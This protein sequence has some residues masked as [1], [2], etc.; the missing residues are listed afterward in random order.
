MLDLTRRAFLQA[1][2]AGG[3]L[4]LRG[5]AGAPVDPIAFWRGEL[6]A[7]A[8]R[9]K[10]EGRLVAAGSDAVPWDEL[11]RL[12]RGRHRDLRRHF[13]FEYYPWYAAHPVRHWQQ[14]DRVPPVDVAANTMPL[15][16]A[17]DSRATAVIEQHA[18]WMAEA[19]VG[20]INLSWWGV[21]SFEDRVT[22]MVMD[23]MHAH[24]I[25]VAFHIEPY[26]PP[27]I[28]RLA[29]DLLYLIRTYGEQRRWDAFFLHER[30]DGT[31]G[32]VFKLFETTLPQQTVDCHGVVR[33]VSDY[34]QDDVW[35]R[36]I[37]RAHRAVDGMFDR[38]TLLSDTWNAVRARDSGLDGIAVY[39]SSVE[40]EA[41]LGFA[42]AATRLGMPFSMNTNAG[43]DEIARRGLPADSCLVPRPFVPRIGEIDWS[44]EDDR[45][46]A[47][48]R[49]VARI[50]ET[51]EWTLLLQTHPW[52][53]NV[54]LGFFLVYITSFNEWHEGSQFEPMRPRGGL[55]A[56][57]R[58]VGYHNPWDG[59]ARLDR[60]T[61]LLRR[62][63]V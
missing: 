29:D 15:L 32:P 18:R 28:D 41:W 45:E 2:L 7:R 63:G 59:F 14:W 21:D 62:L 42:L 38:V 55:T 61:E 50:G 16:G 8:A 43:L 20:V 10:L 23:V 3:G 37:E 57:E 33:A 30:A 56:D 22:P 27:R 54:D 48:A 40:R 9:R 52:L 26:G 6:A 34:V 17:Y 44:R 25:H 13:V 31:A 60:L 51:L 11:G 5:A 47:H 53:G 12:L 35:R 4:P 49:A 36:A 58:S 39:D 46:R 1:C 24:D 19:G